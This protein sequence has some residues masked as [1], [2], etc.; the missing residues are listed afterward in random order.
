MR[1]M[2]EIP[3][4]PL[5][6]SAGTDADLDD[7]LA[8]WSTKKLRR[9]TKTFARLSYLAVLAFMACVLAGVWVDW[10]WLPTA[11]VAGVVFAIAGRGDTVLRAELANR[12]DAERDEAVEKV[13][14]CLSKT[15]TGSEPV[16]VPADVLR[17]LIREGRT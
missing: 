11:L 14:G 16:S 7:M 6:T 17:T 10:R 1:Q 9:T 4:R 2:N 13:R 5:R 12:D 3:R 15:V 8:R